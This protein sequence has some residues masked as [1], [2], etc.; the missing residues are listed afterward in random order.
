MQR[1]TDSLDSRSRRLME[2]IDRS[3]GPPVNRWSVDTRLH[4]LGALLEQIELA[5][6]EAKELTF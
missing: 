5:I 2:H 4:I 3:I 1:R 6:V